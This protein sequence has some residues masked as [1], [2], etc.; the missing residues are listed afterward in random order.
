[1]DS[2]LDAEEDVLEGE[3]D[4]YGEGYEDYTA[5]VTERSGKTFYNFLIF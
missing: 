1:M 5:D 3:R 4:T 2:A